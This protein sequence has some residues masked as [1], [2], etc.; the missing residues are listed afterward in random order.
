MT[1]DVVILTG[2]YYDTRNSKPISMRD[3]EAPHYR[4]GGA[5]Q[6]A[7]HL[8]QNDI[9]V[10]VVDYIQF[11]TAEQI[12]HYLR[13]FLH[14]DKPTIIGLSTTFFIFK[15]GQMPLNL[16]EA[17]GNVKK[18]YPLVKVVAGGANAATINVKKN[19]IDY[20]I[21]SYS[22]DTTLDLFEGLLGK[23]KLKLEYKLTNR[24]FKEN[25]KFDITTCAHRFH[26]DDCIRV[27]ESLPLEIAR[28]CIFKCR[29]CRYPHIGKKK[30]DYIRSIAEI[31]DEILYNY[32]HYKTTNYYILD[33]TFNETPGKVKEFYDMTQRLPFKINW[34]GYLRADLIHRFPETAI[35][36]RDSGL[37]A[38]FFGIESFHPEASKVVGKAWSGKHGKEFILELKNGV[39]KDRVNITLSLII[40]LPP[41]TFEDMQE[42]QQ[43]CVD[44][45]IDRWSWHVLGLSDNPSKYDKSEFD[46]NPAQYGFVVNGNDWR[47]EYT[48]REECTKWFEI[49]RDKNKPPRQ[50]SWRLIECLNMINDVQF[51]LTKHR[52][53]YKEELYLGRE[54][55][56]AEYIKLLDSVT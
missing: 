48:N 50:S 23:K 44:N 29:F 9:S 49:L 3:D 18:E 17:L 14:K 37:V 20:T 46:N 16:L 34:C 27:G 41:E 30:N 51:L 11:M 22:E 32:E 28:G 7:W 4:T 33:D 1:K 6:I 21:Y 19:L 25:T 13:K 54:K 36:L 40:G 53:D 10:Q 42:T 2:I 55:W 31:E 8:R 26:K 39:W 43:W 47:S 24:F 15:Q 5:Y 56:F 45:D 12:E 52:N 38:A 35:W